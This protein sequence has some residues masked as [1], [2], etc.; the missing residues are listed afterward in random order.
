MNVTTLTSSW[1]F[2]RKATFSTL[3]VWLKL[4]Y[5]F[6]FV[7]PATITIHDETGVSEPGFHV[8]IDLATQKVELYAPP[9]DP[10]LVIW[11]GEPD[12]LEEMQSK[13]DVDQVVYADQL[14]CRLASASVVYS[15][16]IANTKAL[17]VSKIK[18]AA[19]D[20]NERLYSAFCEARAV[21]SDWEIALIRQA[22]DISSNAHIQVRPK[23][24]LFCFFMH[25]H[26]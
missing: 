5:L 15:I 21:K 8:V 4:R 11:M 6:F 17:D 1:R 19:A 24:A 26:A 22:N 3:L 20:D 9:V 10:D 23:C 13:Y 2:A 14:E 18:F 16:P 12:S 25:A 7:S